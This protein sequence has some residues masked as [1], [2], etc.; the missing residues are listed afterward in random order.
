MLRLMLVVR[1]ESTRSLAKITHAHARGR[2]GKR[3][4]GY[5]ARFGLVAHVDDA[6]IAQRFIAAFVDRFGVH[7]HQR[8]PFERNRRMYRD[9]A[10]KRRRERQFRDHPRLGH[11]GDIENDETARAVRQIGARPLHVRAA[12]KQRAVG[13]ASL[14]TS[15]PL[16]LA[17]PA[18]DFAWPARIG[19]VDDLIDV[20]LIAIGQ[21]GRMNVAPAVV[22]VAMRAAAAGFVLTESARILGVGQIPDHEALV[23][24]TVRIAAPAGRN[25]LHRGD[26]AALGDLHLQRPGVGRTVDESH[27]ARSRRIGHFDDRQPA[28]PELRGVQIPALARLMHRQ[29]ERRPAFEID[30]ADRLEILDPRFSWWKRR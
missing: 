16:T 10:L 8:A 11:V 20:A 3:K 22:V 30:I 2:F 13:G 26:H 23:V 15:H 5:Q 24:R 28:M 27:E 6:G 29:L 9:E 1:A 25:A 12:M 7:Q 18:R 14:P 21:G 4:Q 17:P 19:D